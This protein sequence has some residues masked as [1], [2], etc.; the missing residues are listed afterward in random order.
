MTNPCLVENQP[1][2]RLISVCLLF[3]AF[4]GSWVYAGGAD[5]FVAGSGGINAPHQQDKPY[6]ILVSIDGFRWDYQDLYPTPALDRIAGEGVRAE[7][8]I[9]VWPTLTF[10]NHYSIATGLYPANHGLVANE[11][12]D[13]ESGIWYAIKKRETVEDG[14]FYA[15]EPIWVT[16][17]TQG[18]VAAAFYFVGTEARI[19]GVY[20]TH[21]RSFDKSIPGEARV[22]QLLDWLAE[23]PGT[24]PHLYTLYFEDVD[25]NTH[26][27][28]PGSKESAEAIRRADSYLARLLRGLDALPHGSEVNIII[29][30]DNGQRD[31]F[32]GAPVFILGDH[33]KLDDMVIIDGGSYAFL[34]F[35]EQDPGRAKFIRD[36]VNSTWRHGRAWL[37]EEAPASW[38]INTNKRFPD[39]I[40]QADPGYGVVSSNEKSDKITAGDHGWAPEAKEMHGIFIASGPN[41]KKGVPLGAVSA[42]DIYPLM[43]GI[44]GLEAP[45]YIDGDPQALRKILKGDTV[46]APT[47]P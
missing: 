8:L 7:R 34:H 41:I 19:R 40:I 36:A 28:G 16:A 9:P 37:P 17:E 47:Q 44:L 18:M 22:D 12:R 27:Y 21:W 31:Y 42:V 45:E 10:P 20:P 23:P 15:G 35:D 29:V 46:S 1:S 39:V 13:P 24:R 32:E 3:L 5:S 4:A 33:V 38:R 25:D 26:W 11:F 6:L 2:H 43:L 30:S 14:R